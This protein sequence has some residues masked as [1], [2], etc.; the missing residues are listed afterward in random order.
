METAVQQTD[1]ELVVAA[2]FL[3]MAEMETA[4]EQVLEL[5]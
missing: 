5:E 1:L 3:R 4:M 2:D